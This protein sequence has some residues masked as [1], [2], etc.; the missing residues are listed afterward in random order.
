MT[1][2]Q[3]CALPILIL[4][5]DDGAARFTRTVEQVMRTPDGTTV[6]YLKVT[7]RIAETERVETIGIMGEPWAEVGFPAAIPVARSEES[8]GGRECVSTCRS[9]WCPIHSK[10][11]K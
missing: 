6:W 1:G 11:K 7:H 4:F 10:K 9:G 5:R 3:T 2:V 8:R